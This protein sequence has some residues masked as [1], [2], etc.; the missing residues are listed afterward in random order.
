MSGSSDIK[1]INTSEQLEM[2]QVAVRC[3]PLCMLLCVFTLSGCGD[4]S[5]IR[6]VNGG[7]HSAETMSS[8]SFQRLSSSS[9]SSST[10]GS[11]VWGTTR[12]FCAF[13]SLPP[14]NFYLPDRSLRSISY[15]A[16]SDWQW[17]FAVMCLLTMQLSCLK[18]HFCLW[19]KTWEPGD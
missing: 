7:C 12:S 19:L 13:L 16:R 8:C 5:N 14:G 15:S 4:V 17:H 1:L 11:L 9:G 18:L 6:L 2:K 10:V 3:L